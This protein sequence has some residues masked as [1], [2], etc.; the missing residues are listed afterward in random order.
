MT[1]TRVYTFSA[2]F[3]P[4]RLNISLFL[5]FSQTEQGRLHVLETAALPDL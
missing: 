5:F 2:S 3:L 1:R 4:R